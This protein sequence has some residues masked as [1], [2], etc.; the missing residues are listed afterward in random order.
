[1]KGFYLKTMG[2]QMNDHDSEVITGILL[3]LGYQPRAKVDEAD[4]ILYNTCCV[5]ENPERK[6]YGHISAF[7][8]LKEKN[9]DLLIGICGCMPQ[10]K[11]ELQQ[12]LTKLPHV[13]LIFG[14]HNIHRLP[15]LLDR[16]SSGERVVE[17]WDESQYEE[18]Q[19]FRDDLPVQRNDGLKAFVN[20][21]YGCTNF[22][23][24]CIVPYVRGKEHSRTPEKIRED[25]LGLVADGYKEITLLGQNVNAYGKDLSED[26]SFSALLADLNSIDGL[27]RIRFTTSHPRDMGPELISALATLDKVCEHLH[28]PV[29]AGSTSLLRR[30]NRGYTREFYLDLVD[31]VRRAV[32]GI[33]LT[34]DLIVG[35]PGETD[36]DF[37]ATLSLVRE[38]G[39]SSAFTF[40]YSPRE[41]T[42]AARLPNQIPEE[43]KKERIY[44]LIR[45]QNA[46][47]DSHMQL[48]IGTAQELLVE[49]RSKDGLIGRTRTN[50]QVH[51]TG[52]DELVG[53]L[54]SVEITNASTWSLQGRIL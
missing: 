14:T 38:V 29:Q 20:V 4:L 45:V 35:F 21:I 33:S 18:G 9:P 11:Q 25:V 34:T 19:D 7:R 42:P 54:V 46:I 16:A 27:A 32:P 10:Q 39:F 22:C 53:S 41:G 52:P 2:C 28:L 3:S 43:I 47:S 23:T 49:G 37:Q 24:Y 50:R 40:I 31:Q 15:E 17:I 48:L 8:R 6:V 13:D 30:M 44:E 26:T 36:E 5:R 12:M 51:F 1:M